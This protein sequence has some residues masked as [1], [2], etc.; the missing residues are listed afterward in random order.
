MD[1]IMK[2]S[3]RNYKGGLEWTGG[4]RL[5]DLD[6]ADDIALNRDLTDRHATVNT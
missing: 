2:K 5:C 6:F 3:L 1:W 4:S